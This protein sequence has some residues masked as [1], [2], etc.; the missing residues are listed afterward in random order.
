MGLKKAEAVLIGLEP[1]IP[2]FFFLSVATVIVFRG[3]FGRALAERLAGRPSPEDTAEIAAL[4]AE[5]E[6]VHQRLEEV[7]QRLDFAE[8]LLVERREQPGGLPGSGA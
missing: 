8:R 6:E 4:R 3:P 7:E 1:L 5:L 2:V